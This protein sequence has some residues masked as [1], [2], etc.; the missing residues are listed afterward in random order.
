MPSSP[1]P[2]PMACGSKT[3]FEH[4]LLEELAAISL[5]R[6]TLCGPAHFPFGPRGS[7]DSGQHSKLR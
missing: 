3:S 1:E 2:D 7:T 4:L 5:R 6:A